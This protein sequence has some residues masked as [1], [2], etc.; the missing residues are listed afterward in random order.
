MTRRRIHWRDKPA[1]LCEE[2]NCPCRHV[3]EIDRTQPPWYPGLQIKKGQELCLAGD[4]RLQQRRDEHGLVTTCD[5]SA[6]R[7][8]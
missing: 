8:I 1:S 5:T 7:R 4:P 3:A 6:L 2:M